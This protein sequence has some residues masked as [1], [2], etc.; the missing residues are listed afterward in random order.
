MNEKNEKV[1]NLLEEFLNLRELY[2]YLISEL[3][4]YNIVA[5]E[6]GLYSLRYIL[7]E[8]YIELTSEK[9]EDLRESVEELKNKIEKKS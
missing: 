1:E 5:L 8:I 2:L 6:L 4:N 7:E 3:N 9:L